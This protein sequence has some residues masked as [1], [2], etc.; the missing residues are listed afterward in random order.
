MDGLITCLFHTKHVLHQKIKNVPIFAV[1]AKWF[2]PSHFI[3]PLECHERTNWEHTLPVTVILF[4]YKVYGVFLCNGFSHL[5]QNNNNMYIYMYILHIVWCSFFLIP[6]NRGWAP[7]FYFISY[8]EVLNTHLAKV[9]NF[10]IMDEVWCRTTHLVKVEENFATAKCTLTTYPQ[11]ASKV[12]NLCKRLPI[13]CISFSSASPPPPFQRRKKKTVSD[14]GT[15]LVAKK[16][17]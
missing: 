12:K 7:T 11:S 1:V 10:A 6:F 9:R 8:S 17:H 15:V 16:V 3:R 2:A 5:F 4:T 14:L 13:A